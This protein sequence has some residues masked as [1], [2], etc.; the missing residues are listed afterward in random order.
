MVYC[1]HENN[2]LRFRKELAK[3]MGSLFLKNKFVIALFFAAV[4]LVPTVKQVGAE[5]QCEGTPFTHSSWLAR[6]IAGA[7]SELYAEFGVYS[8][9]P[10]DYMDC[11]NLTVVFSGWSVRGVEWG[12]TLGRNGV[13]TALY[14]HLEMASAEN[15]FV[16]I[17]L[18]PIQDS[19]L[20]GMMWYDSFMHRDVDYTARID[21]VTVETSA[22]GHPTYTVRLAITGFLGQDHLIPV[23][24]WDAIYAD[25]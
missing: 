1:N 21:S 19:L 23:D 18:N 17:Q 25:H 4:L 10:V 3:T 9:S 6:D 20:Q 7:A 24:V 15:S 11:E 8:L 5:E 2:G 13:V 22:F 14:T 12:P 16:K